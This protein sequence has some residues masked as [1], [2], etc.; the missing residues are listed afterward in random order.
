VV[1]RSAEGVTPAPVWPLAALAALVP[2][3][4][5]AQFRGLALAA[6]LGL[7]GLVL[8]A[9]R[10][11]GAWVWPG[12]AALWATLALLGW[13][14]IS[15]LWAAEPGRALAT[16]ASLGTFAALGAAAARIVAG[17]GGIDTAL[18]AGLAVGATLAVIDQLSGNAL[19]AAIRGLPA[20]TPTL[21]FGLK[22][23]V[24]LF[25]VLLPIAVF[26]PAAPRWLRAM[27]LPVTL[28]A[29]LLV[30]AEAAKIAAAAGVLAAF[31][32]WAFGRVVIRVVAG[33]TAVAV[34]V[35]PLV[36][37]ALLPR[38]PPLDPW[39]PSAAHRVLIWD[40]V[41][42]RIAERPVFGWGGEAARGIPG[43]RDNFAPETLTRFGLDSPER[44]AWFAMSSA[45]RLPLHTHN[46]ALQLWLE[47]GA[48]GALFGAAAVWVL[49]AAAARC[50]NAPAVAGAYAAAAVVGGLSFGVWQ[51]WWWGA[52]L[53]VACLLAAQRG[54][55]CPE[56]LS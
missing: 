41:V 6:V 33:A 35:A 53:L 12:G 5:V 14:A 17:R 20:A 23:A 49:G 3:L 2:T 4:A 9:R 48:I 10:T 21:G 22:P 51:E 45:Q 30:P 56:R 24:S 16:A 8:A 11:T 1:S 36:T 32:A 27:L 43:G 26:A 13:L 39:P 15:T 29:L 42:S 50:A 52:M 55:N 37:A 40:F 44:R 25:A 46:M 54:I 34:I 31:A 38:L 28:A 47:L 19:R 18:A 7:A